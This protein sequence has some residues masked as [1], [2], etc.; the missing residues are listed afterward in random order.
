MWFAAPETFAQHLA[1]IVGV[2][3]E[4]AGELPEVEDR[5]RDV[6]GI[7]ADSPFKRL[8]HLVGTRQDGAR[9]GQEILHRGAGGDDGRIGLRLPDRRQRRRAAG[10]LDIADAG[11][12][13]EAER[14]LRVGLDRRL[15]LNVQARDHHARVLRIEIERLHVADLDAVE[16]HLAADGE[17]GDRVLEDDGERRVGGLA[18]LLRASQ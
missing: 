12:A 1:E 6:V 2:R 11:Q 7:V 4:R 9:A 18:E 15:R 14:H 5:E 8:Q 3:G 16:D 10:H 17:A 13:L